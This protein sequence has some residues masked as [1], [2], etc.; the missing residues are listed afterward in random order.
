LPDIA[1]PASQMLK[2]DNPLSKKTY[3]KYGPFDYGGNT[4]EQDETFKDCIILGPY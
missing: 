1:V 2:I 3:D 4:E